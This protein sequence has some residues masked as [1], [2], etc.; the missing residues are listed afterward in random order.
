MV[1]RTT[2]KLTGQRKQCPTCGELF[3]CNSAFEKHRTGRMNSRRCLTVEEMS[4]AGMFRGEDQFWRGSR[5]SG[6][7]ID[8]A[9]YAWGLPRPS[10]QA[11]DGIPDGE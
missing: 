4:A 10:T 1:T 3:T 9:Y 8:G 5:P 7:W 6:S 11:V 2:A